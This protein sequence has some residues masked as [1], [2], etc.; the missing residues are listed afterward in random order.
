[1]LAEHPSGTAASEPRDPSAATSLGLRPASD[2]QPDSAN[3]LVLDGMD[4][5]AVSLCWP[6]DT[7][8][9][10]VSY[11]LMTS[12]S[13][14]GPW[15]E[16]FDMNITVADHTCGWASYLNSGQTYYWEL[17]VWYNH[18][19]LGDLHNES[20]VVTTTLPEPATLTYSLVTD[21]SARLSWNDPA[22]YGGNLSFYDYEV[23]WGPTGGSTSSQYF[24][25]A[26]TQSLV[27]SGLSASTSYTADVYTQDE[28]SW[29]Y[30]EYISPGDGSISNIPTFTMPAPV[31]AAASA[32]P[33]RVDVGQAVDFGCTPSGGVGPYS[34]SWTFGDGGSA[35]GQTP[36]HTYGLAGRMD[37]V[38]T[39]TDDLGSESDGGVYVNVTSDP[40]VGTP[41][42]SVPSVDLGGSV[43]FTA[44]TTPG[45]GDLAFLW[46][47]GGLTNCTNQT[48]AV[49]IC[50]PESINGTD[51]VTV[52][53]T[54]SNGYAVTSSPL[55]FTV[56]L[57]PTQGPPIAS[58]PGSVD[59]G[60]RV[61]FFA[62]IHGGSGGGV[63]NWSEGGLPGCAPPS[64]GILNCTPTAPGTFTISYRY[65]DSDG[66][67]AA[68]NTALSYTVYPDPTQAVPAISPLASPD[69]G[70][71]VEF[72]AV[73]TGGSGGGSYAWSEG[74]LSGCVATTGGTLACTPTGAGTFVVSYTWTDSNGA[75][76]TGGTL[77]SFTVHP[78]PTQAPPYTAPHGSADVSQTVTFAAAVKGGAGAGTYAWSDGGLSG[79]APS[80]LV[81]LTC[82][83]TSAG[84]FTVSYLWTDA[85]EVAATGGTS[86][87][88]VVY[89]DPTVSAPAASP[90]SVAVG[91]SVSLSV[92][93]TP[94]S[95]QLAYTWN[96]LPPGCP[97]EDGPTMTCTVTTAGT[98]RL[99][100]QVIDSNGMQVTGAVLVLQVSEGSRSTFGGLGSAD[101]WVGI[102][103][104]ALAGAIA[105]ILVLRGRK[106]KSTGSPA[107]A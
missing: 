20:N 82:T 91:K 99:S 31:S 13:A 36:Q 55:E 12:G 67:R 16:S 103:A 29:G 94:G 19:G 2:P 95:G 58:H 62:S 77:C 49:L 70:Q 30:G 97:A 48:T 57:D 75:T 40:T 104:V 105:G 34:F 37:A 33:A 74:G 64:G 21:T 81:A 7:A 32:T 88:F 26:G 93:T 54:D 80:Q 42:P 17:W 51:P 85:D 83:P 76:A 25:S 71:S 60:Q 65:I 98:Y 1:L 45:S 52:Q 107:G 38:C 92:T 47:S 59:V 41:V 3:W 10:F 100:V 11:E 78:D 56:H 89:P 90:T 102:G 14:S 96:G 18:L 5:T 27:V 66:V 61:Y 24:Y 79:C 46:S 8:A 28:I 43:S 86:L 106:R 4:P 73:V 44:P 22:T 53:V 72:T 101:L 6:E 23:I 69:L 15:S 50:G 9:N 39:V 35:G 87:S 63:V 84:S 68:G